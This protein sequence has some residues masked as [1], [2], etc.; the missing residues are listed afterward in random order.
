MKKIGKAETISDY[1]Q[2]ISYL[3][4]ILSHLEDL[5]SL[6]A[7][8]DL[9]EDEYKDTK[10]IFNWIEEV[11]QNLKDEREELVQEEIKQDEKEIEAMN[12]EFERSRLW[13]I[14]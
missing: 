2:Q 10:N 8:D 4:D 9:F 7:K 12:Y 1:N 11:Q 14:I 5:Q 13:W 6:Y 3:E